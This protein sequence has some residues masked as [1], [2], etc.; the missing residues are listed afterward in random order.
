MII[1]LIVLSFFITSFAFADDITTLSPTVV[2]ATKM[3]AKSFDLPVS[4]DVV[5]K[6]VLQDGK[7]GASIS[8]VSQRIPGVVINNRNNYAQE[9]AISSRGFGA[10][11]AFGVK[12][13]RLYIDGIP[14]NTADGQGASGSITFDS[15]DRIEFMRGPFSA[16]YGNSSGGVVQAFTRDGAKDPTLTG[17]FSY[18]KWDTFRESSTFEGQAGNLNYIVS[19]SEI[20]S[21]GY[22]DFSKFKKDNLNSKFTYQ[23]NPDTNA[24]VLLNYNNKP[25]T[26]DPQSLNP[27]Q[28]LANPKQFQCSSA[29]TCSS[30]KQTRLFRQQTY[31][32]FILDH[33]LSEKQSIKLTSYFGIR[34]NLQYLTTSASEIN[35]NY[36]GVD[37]R[38][39]FKDTLFSKPFNVTAGLNY[40][41][42]EDARKRYS[43]S[44]GNKSA[45]TRNETQKAYNFD[46]YAQASFEPTEQLLL[47]AGIRHSK[48]TFNT[49][50]IYGGATDDSGIQVFTNT[51]PVFGATFKVNSQLNI[52]ANYGR[53]FET[54][55][56]AEMGYRDV[57]T[58]A[59]PNLSMAPSRSK[60]YEIG[61]KAFITDNTRINVALFK[62]DTKNEIIAYNYSSA[63]VFTSY[64][65]VA[66]TE[67]KGIELSLDSRLPYNFNLYG[68]YSIM[69]AEFRNTFDEKNASTSAVTVYP[70]MNI[71]ATYKNT[72]FAELSWKYPAYGFSTATEV[73]YFSDT[74]A[75][76]TNNVAYR[77]GAYTIANIRGSLEQKVDRWTIKE[78]IRIDNIF[79]RTYV[80]NVKV[81][82]T[83]PFEPGL[84]R[85]YT[86]GLSASYKF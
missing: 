84:D 70:G 6:D 45:Y 49:K 40:D 60:N 12:G 63:N 72:G 51:S 36:G 55:T 31:T 13:V 39:N 37:F 25:Y 35:R 11:S 47:I 58:G 69:D 38:W 3:E 8:E 41:A 62:I 16:L 65:S 34:D 46:Q 73:V 85:N 83:T 82:T 81:N 27:S 7:V 80:A 77:P 18:G 44:N 32:G 43:V 20:T 21:D 2:T 75:Y 17:S 61:A 22:R 5:G 56:F 78:F 50:D 24:T 29:T 14:L 86:L 23:I 52:Y 28:Y 79:D 67:R 9:L 19:A 4:I 33:N 53:G 1:R 74:Y 68:A 59:G 15:L 48:I 30:T 76:D 10:R 57:D 66:Q 26:L 42:M 64:A 71:P 54:P